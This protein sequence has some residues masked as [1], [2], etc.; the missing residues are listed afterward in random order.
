LDSPNIPPI[1]IPGLDAEKK[2][3]DLAFS[4]SQGQYKNKWA[5]TIPK[6]Q[7]SQLLSLIKKLFLKNPRKELIP[8]PSLPGSDT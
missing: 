8:R 4:M 5:W 3:T 1:K 2:N 6:G 7:N